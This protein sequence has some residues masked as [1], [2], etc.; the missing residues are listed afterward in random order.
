[1]TK[2]QY[3]GVAYFS[4]TNIGKNPTFNELERLT[5][6]TH[7]FDFSKDIYGEKLVVDFFHRIRD[8]KKFESS[9]KL[10]DQISRDVNLAKNYF[11]R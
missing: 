10:V 7:L 5:V 4:V 9:Q 11:S 3:E 2:T 1:V 8:E 6:E